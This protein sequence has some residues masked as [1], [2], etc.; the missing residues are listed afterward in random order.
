MDTDNQYINREK[1]SLSMTRTTVA[2][3]VGGNAGRMI[4]KLL[5]SR[6]AFLEIENII[7]IQSPTQCVA[8]KV[9]CTS[10]LYDQVSARLKSIV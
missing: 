6:K 5:F 8:R 3:D 4:L 9:V 10:S 2:V 1:S 7:I